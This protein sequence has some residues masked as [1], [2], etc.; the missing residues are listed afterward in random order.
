MYNGEDGWDHYLGLVKA[1][2]ASPEMKIQLTE[3]V[4][5]LRRVLGEDWP[6]KS[7]D[8][9]HPILWSLRMISGAM[10]D[11]ILVNWGGCVSALER[12][13][14][15]ESLLAKLRRPTGFE[16]SIAELEVAGR[17]AS[18]GCAVELEPEVGVKK[19]DLRC[20]CGD[21]E[22]LVEVKTLNAAP[23]SWKATKTLV[24][25]ITACMSIHPSGIIFKTLSRPHLEEVAGILERE[26]DRA[27]SGGV[28]V[29]VDLDKVLKVYLVPNELPNSAGLRAEWI[30]KQEDMGV[31][32][33]GGGMRGPPYNVSQEHRAGTKIDGFARK[34]QIPPECPGVLVITGHFLFG[35]ADNAERFVDHIIEKV[36]ELE[37]IQA[38]VLVG[39]NIVGGDEE[40]TITDRRDFVFVSNNI[41]D[42]VREDIVIVKNR[43]CKFKLDYRHLASLLAAKK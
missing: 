32:P 9:H 37:N 13:R 40:T 34:C 21:L 41:C 7:R 31:M 33:R 35:D 24:D 4:Q 2:K 17:L 6:S 25:V 8:S 43:F 19:P 36:Y 42:Y 27:V 28:P 5:T 29:E 15:F 23:E 30:R 1:A 10:G 14:N 11:G 22:F 26:T 20:R 3:A 38:V 39:G 16:S 12:T 18:N